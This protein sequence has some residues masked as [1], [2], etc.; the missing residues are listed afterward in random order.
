MWEADSFYLSTCLFVNK[1][2][3]YRNEEIILFPNTLCFE[4]I[5]ALEHTSE[6]EKEFESKIQ[7][8]KALRNIL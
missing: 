3:D 2:N 4:F 7:I 6:W 8:T 1:N 5:K